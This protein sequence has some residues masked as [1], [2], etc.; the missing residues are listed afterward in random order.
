MSF[1]R[2]DLRDL[3]PYAQDPTPVDL[4][5]SDNTNLW[6]PHPAALQ[7]LAESAASVARYP[8]AYG[9]AVRAAV[10]ARFGVPM[11]CVTTGC[12]SD[13]LIDAA[14]RGLA[15]PG[16]ALA[17]LAPTFSMVEHA[18]LT[19]SLERRPYLVDY[20]GGGA[21]PA[22]EAVLEGAPALVYLCTPNNPTGTGLP[23]PWV[24][25]LLDR[26]ATLAEA[27]IVL[28]DEAYAHFTDQSWLE[29]APGHGR[30]LVLR[31]M[32]KA[33][34]LAGLRVGFG[35][36][37]PAVLLELN[38]ARGPFKVGRSAEAAAAAALADGSSWLDEIIH[39]TLLNR[40]RLDAELRS[41]GWAPL[42]SEA[43][44]VLIPVAEPLWSEVADRLARGRIG[45][46]AVRF[47]DGSRWM[48]LTVGPWPWMER[49][50][51]ELGEAP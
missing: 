45:V 11:D 36:A 39:E 32:S 18:A 15:A 30:L 24:D 14:F 6:G 3:A 43:N 41:R 17:Y 35:V 25:A 2:S 5:L 13:D 33:Y 9:D 4:D 20:A 12:G 47:P 51:A 31:T 22:P 27:P 28:I 50:L 46:R 19:N 1:P 10:A 29:R 16:E 8:T 42:P 48:R 44:F 34:G 26:V 38:K 21:L 37:A 49:L 40:A 23:A 7:A